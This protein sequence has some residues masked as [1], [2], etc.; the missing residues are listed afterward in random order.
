MFTHEYEVVEAGMGTVYVG[1]SLRK[2]RRAF[3]VAVRHIRHSL[4]GGVTVFKDGIP[5]KEYDAEL[6]K[7]AF[8]FS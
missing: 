4:S 3:R 2:A 8:Q 1:K 5:V 7:R 6:L